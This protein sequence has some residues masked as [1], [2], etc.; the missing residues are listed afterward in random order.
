MSTV[1]T[2]ELSQALE[3]LLK[4]MNKKGQLPSLQNFIL[5]S[6]IQSLLNAYT[7]IKVHINWDKIVELSINSPPFNLPLWVYALDKLSRLGATTNII[8]E[9]SQR[10][11]LEKVTP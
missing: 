7:D 10:K 6:I 3:T 2:G 5:V 4:Y 1:G 9:L 8:T 11:K